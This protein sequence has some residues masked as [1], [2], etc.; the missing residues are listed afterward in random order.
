MDRFESMVWNQK[1]KLQ[2]TK[3]KINRDHNFDFRR[4]RIHVP[5]EF[6][7]QKPP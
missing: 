4:L 6:I 3:T 5:F 1:I 2:S 7:K